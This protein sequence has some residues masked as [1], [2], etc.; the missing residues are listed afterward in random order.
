MLIGEFEHPQHGKYYVFHSG[1]RYAICRT[2][3][4][5]V[6]CGYASLSEALKAKGF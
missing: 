5:S 3:T 2:C 6:H 1:G 4:L